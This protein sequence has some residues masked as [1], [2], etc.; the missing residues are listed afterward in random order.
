MDVIYKNEK[1]KNIL[2]AALTAYMRHGISCTTARQVAGIAG[3]GKSTIFE[4]FKDM[5]ELKNKAF[6]LFLR[7]TAEGR[8]SIREA[9]RED[10]VRALSAYIDT[11]IHLALR[12]PEK[13]L[14]L[15]QYIVEIFV[16]NKD[17]GAVKDE[18]RRKLFPSMIALAEELGGIIA[19][20]VEL[21]KMKPAM[22]VGVEKLTYAVLALIREIHAQAFM[23][24]GTELEK[25]CREIQETIFEVLGIQEPEARSQNIEK[26]IEVK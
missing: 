14:L 6:S 20:G 24:E 16:G 9:A 8:Q 12:E 1:E 2:E 19:R 3:V 7:E 25:A 26:S 21:G 22:N 5:E 11:T 10:P 17:V 4:Y 18:Y 13:L 15:T 23:R